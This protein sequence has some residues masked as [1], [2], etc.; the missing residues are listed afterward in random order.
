MELIAKDK[1]RNITFKK[2]KEGLVRKMHEFAT[3]C[4]VDACIIIYGPRNETGGRVEP[5]IWPQDLDEVKRIVGVYKSKNKDSGSKSSG[6]SDF[7]HDRNRRIEQELTKLRRKN[8]ES[9]YP[10]WPDFLNSKTEAELRGLSAALTDKFEHVKT[11]V[12][13]LKRN[14]NRQGYDG[15]LVDFRSSQPVSACPNFCA[16]RVGDLVYQQPLPSMHVRQD[17]VHQ[18][19]MMTT[20]LNN[21]ADGFMQF[22][23]SSAFYNR[24]I[25]YE[26][27]SEIV[28]PLLCLNTRPVAR[29]YAPTSLLP[30][31]PPFLHMMPEVAPP[32]MHFA[33]HEE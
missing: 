16:P 31:L 30:P 10:T 12:D 18:N 19:S 15:N 7:F 24:Q 3:L 2:R 22:D 32:Q 6:L 17:F 21:E 33:N 14:S 28:D 5:E 1:S 25:F 23:G 29:Y 26:T 4:D 20:M 13:F 11:R 8:L 9:K 27:K